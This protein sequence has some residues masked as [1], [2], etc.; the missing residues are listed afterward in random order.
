[1]KTTESTDAGRFHQGTQPTDTGYTFVHINTAST[2]EAGHADAV[3]NRFVHFDPAGSNDLTL[4]LDAKPSRYSYGALFSYEQYIPLFGGW[5]VGA[6]IAL[7]DYRTKLNLRYVGQT[8]V[9][10]GNLPSFFSG[11]YSS[12]TSGR[13][14]EKLTFNRFDLYELQRGGTSQIDLWARRAFFHTDRFQLNGSVHLTI[15][16]I[17]SAP[18]SYLYSPTMGSNGH[19]STGSSLHTQMQVWQNGDHSITCDLRGYIGYSLPEKEERVIGMSPALKNAS[20]GHY[21]LLAQRD[22]T[23]NT[24]LFPQQIFYVKTFQY[25]RE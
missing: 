23:A 13:A 19:W 24:P 14:Q 5:Y 1:M 16:T 4:K 18:G 11:Q 7:S 6:K 3:N 20:F 17:H 9:Q 2:V 25:H 8:I 10:P 22:S 15:P 21:N 12:D